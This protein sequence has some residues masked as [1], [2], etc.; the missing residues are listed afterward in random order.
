MEWDLKNLEA[1][2]VTEE[3][4]IVV[5]SVGLN[6]AEISKRNMTA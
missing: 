3:G 2:A 6:I 4:E 1:L 5:L